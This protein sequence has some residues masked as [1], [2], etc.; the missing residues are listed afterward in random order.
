MQSLFPLFRYAPLLH[1]CS[2][3]HSEEKQGEKGGRLSALLKKSDT[4]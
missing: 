1:P 4:P 2:C 3:K